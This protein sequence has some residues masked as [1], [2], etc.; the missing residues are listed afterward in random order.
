MTAEKSQCLGTVTKQQLVFF[1][2]DSVSYSDFLNVQIIDSI[3]Y[4][5]VV[6]SYECL[7]NPFINQN[8][9]NSYLHMTISLTFA[10][11]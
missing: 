1:G 5:P 8:S 3:I 11:L 4:L 6:R 9:A 10:H 7:V 2:T